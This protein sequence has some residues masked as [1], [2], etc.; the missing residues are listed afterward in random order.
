[1]PE[2]LTKP[3]KARRLVPT[4]YSKPFR[5]TGRYDSSERLPDVDS[6]LDRTLKQIERSH[7]SR[8]HHA[9]SFDTLWNKVCRK[10][11]E[12]KNAATYERWK[13]S[14]D[15][16]RNLGEIKE[17]DDRLA[18]AWMSVTL[19]HGE[20]DDAFIEYRHADDFEALHRE[21]KDLKPRIRATIDDALEIAI[22]YWIEAKNARDA[23]DTLRV[24]HALVECHL[25]IGMTLSAKTESESKSDAGRMQGKKVRDEMA[26]VVVEVLR[27]IEVDK[28]MKEPDYLWGKVVQLIEASP[29]HSATLKAYDTWATS[30]KKV[31]EGNSTADRFAETLRKWAKSKSPQ[32][33]EIAVQHRSICYQIDRLQSSTSK[34]I[35][36]Q[37]KS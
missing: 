25:Y 1:M 21:R 11:L 17:L 3:V 9:R 20:G 2:F 29:Q 8:G 34:A 19:V 24:L 28:K 18:A 22:A 5:D 32:Y 33:K 6:L 31:Q 13:T 35:K 12:K 26:A 4:I 14:E 15:M 27:S 37:A 23:G 30:G 7:E 10:L 16:V 36:R